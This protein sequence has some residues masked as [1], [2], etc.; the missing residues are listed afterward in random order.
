MHVGMALALQNLGREVSDAQVWAEELRLA[1]QAEPLGFQSVW[2]AEHHFTDYTLCPDP[3]QLLTW[4]AGRTRDIE[5]GT[6]VVV[7]PWHDP[8]RVAESVAVLDL[9]SGGRLVLGI[10]RGLGRIEFE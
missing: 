7:L 5:L 4:L 2:A 9:L 6:M 1:E 10:G 8:V 3:L